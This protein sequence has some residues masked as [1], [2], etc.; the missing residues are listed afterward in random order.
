M[1]DIDAGGGGLRGAEAYAL[2]VVP[3]AWHI[4]GVYAGEEER[5]RCLC[6]LW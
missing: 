6:R 1:I 5:Q 4:V 3:H 2:E